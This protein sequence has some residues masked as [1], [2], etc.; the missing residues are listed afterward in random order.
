MVAVLVPN[1]IR[2]PIAEAFQQMADEQ[3]KKLTQGVVKTDA[4]TTNSTTPTPPVSEMD[5][6]IGYETMLESQEM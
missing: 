1:D 3:V 6:G 5:Y 4:P 2:K